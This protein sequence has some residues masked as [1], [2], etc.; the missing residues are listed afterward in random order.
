MQQGRDCGSCRE[1]DLDPKTNLKASYRRERRGRREKNGRSMFLF[2][3]S[4]QIIL[5]LM[6]GTSMR[7]TN[8]IVLVYLC[9]LGDLCG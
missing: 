1:Q 9:V 5:L 2:Q 7:T 4:E 3:I 6:S 8:Q